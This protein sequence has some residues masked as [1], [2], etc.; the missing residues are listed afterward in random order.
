MDSS[1]TSKQNK[2]IS[3]KQIK[4][5]YNAN[6]A[7][8]PLDQLTKIPK[9]EDDEYLAGDLIWVKVFRD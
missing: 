6:N 3:K 7:I 2:S 1:K 5:P 8:V 9:R 4:L